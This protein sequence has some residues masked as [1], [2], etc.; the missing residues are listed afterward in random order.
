MVVVLLIDL[1]ELNKML[2]LLNIR[3]CWK[4]IFIGKVLILK[5][6]IKFKKN[7]KKNEKIKLYM[8]ICYLL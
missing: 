7:K 2:F 3:K 6:L 4:E 1:K 8:F 5:N